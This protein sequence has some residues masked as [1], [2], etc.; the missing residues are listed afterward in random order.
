MV[1][2]CVAILHCSF[3][4]RFAI[5]SSILVEQS[6]FRLYVRFCCDCV[7]RGACLCDSSRC[8]SFFVF[9][10]IF[11]DRL[12]QGFAPKLQSSATSVLC[13][14]RARV[15]CCVVLQ[16]ARFGQR[17]CFARLR[18]TFVVGVLCFCLC[19][20]FM[21]GYVCRVHFAPG[22]PGVEEKNRHRPGSTGTGKR[23]RRDPSAK[24]SQ[25]GF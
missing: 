15:L 22:H 20:D 1:E 14:V 8:V 5:F 18:W 7:I 23:A 2:A 17:G 9:A 16:F 13:A 12:A 11:S 10:V 6:V 19:V 4:S 3:V 21:R 24:N 25:A